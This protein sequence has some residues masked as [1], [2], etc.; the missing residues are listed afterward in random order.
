MTRAEFD[1]EVN[2]FADLKSFC[3]DNDCDLLEDVYS[4]DEM[5]EYINEELVNFANEYGRWQE[6]RDALGAINESYYWY[7]HDGDLDFE[8]ID[9]EYEAYR[10]DVIRWAEENDVFDPEEEPEEEEAVGEPT[11][12]APEEEFPVEDPS[13]LQSCFAASMETFRAYTTEK[14]AAIA[15]AIQEATDRAAR[16]EAAEAAAREAERA[17]K[18]QDDRAFMALF[19]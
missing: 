13:F 17:E 11:E 8:P 4:D 1:E 3:W 10:S 2:D 12:E 14:E 15:K 5:N 19:T 7:R 18:E 6:L 16:C 9:Y